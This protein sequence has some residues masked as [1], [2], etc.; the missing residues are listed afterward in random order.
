MNPSQVVDMLL[1]SSR[2]KRHY[3]SASSTL[4]VSFPSSGKAYL[5]GIYVRP[6]IR[7]QGMGRS[8]MQEVTSD[9]DADGVTLALHTRDD[10]VPFFNQFGFNV[11]GN[12]QFGVLMERPPASI[13]SIGRA[14]V[15]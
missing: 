9:A 5:Y 1:E 15:S 7:G 6:E 13:A 8:L 2:M 3:G 11:L 10:L 14:S 4:N 12:D